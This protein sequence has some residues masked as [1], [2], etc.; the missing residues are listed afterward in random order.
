MSV[1]VVCH[2][3]SSST[4]VRNCTRDEG[5]PFEVGKQVLTSS[6]RKAAAVIIFMKKPCGIYAARLSR[7]GAGVCTE[8]LIR[9]DLV[10][11]SHNVGGDDTA[12]LLPS[13]TADFTVQVARSA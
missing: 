7:L 6:H 12:A 8:N 3:Y 1:R 2:E 10:T 13:E 11:E 5:R 9:I 4:T